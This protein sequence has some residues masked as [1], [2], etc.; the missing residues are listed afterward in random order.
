MKR[1]Y[2]ADKQDSYRG[3]NRKAYKGAYLKWK[4]EN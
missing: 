1:V 3:S 2:N 4:I